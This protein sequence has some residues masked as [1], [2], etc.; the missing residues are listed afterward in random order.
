MRLRR[1]VGEH[2]QD[3]AFPGKAAANFEVTRLAAVGG[4]GFGR[5]PREDSPVPS[6]A[7]E[8]GPRGRPGLQDHQLPQTVSRH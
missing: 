5:L 8:R 4:M 3:L 2:E 7:A 1:Q 6:C